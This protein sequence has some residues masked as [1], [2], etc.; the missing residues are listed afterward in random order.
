MKKWNFMSL[1]I[2]VVFVLGQGTS[3]QMPC[4]GDP[5]YD[6]T[7]EEAAEILSNQISELGNK[8]FVWEVDKVGIGL[9]C[10]DYCPAGDL[11]VSSGTF[12]DGRCT[13]TI[14]NGAKSD[15]L[16]DSTTIVLKQKSK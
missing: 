7:S 9:T 11:I 8:H 16:G 4:A 14:K 1:L 12:K 6:L 2:I 13:Y 3:A 5:C 10:L 15:I